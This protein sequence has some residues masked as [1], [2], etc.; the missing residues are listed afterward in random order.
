MLSNRY[1]LYER[2][3]E[4]FRWWMLLHLKST[5]NR[6]QSINIDNSLQTFMRDVISD[7]GRKPFLQW[8]SYGVMLRLDVYLNM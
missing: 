5:F 8:D 6:S 7:M 3:R 2:D 4:R 1:Y